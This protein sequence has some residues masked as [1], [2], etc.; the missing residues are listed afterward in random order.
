[1][2]RKV[3]ANWDVCEANGICAALA[4]DVFE[5]DDDDQLQ[6]LDDEV[7]DENADRV[8]RA[9]DGCPKSALTIQDTA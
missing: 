1:M 7:T 9:V 8:D 6:I 4:P 3:V 2:T 5:L